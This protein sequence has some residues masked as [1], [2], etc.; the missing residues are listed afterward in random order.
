MSIL[1]NIA[2][3]PTAFSDPSSGLRPDA[4][5]SPQG[6]TAGPARI[7]QGNTHPLQEDTARI[8]DLF[9]A[10]PMQAAKELATLILREGGPQPLLRRLV[11]ELVTTPTGALIEMLV[12]PKPTAD[13]LLLLK[14]NE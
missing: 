14:R 12:N 10:D 7:T 8:I 9:K 4:G 11:T 3:T 1:S 6:P 5:P 13:S 2:M